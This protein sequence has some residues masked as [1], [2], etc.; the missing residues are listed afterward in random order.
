MSV[1]GD[2]KGLSQLLDTRNPLE[3]FIARY[4][5]NWELSGGVRNVVGAKAVVGVDRGGRGTVPCYRQAA[6]N[7]Y[8]HMH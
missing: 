6:V 2:A 7:V 8:M 3:Y 1:L 4:V 5:P